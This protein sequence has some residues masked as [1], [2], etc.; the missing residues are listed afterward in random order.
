M[1]SFSGTSLPLVVVTALV[2]TITLAAAGCGQVSQLKGRKSYKD[3]NTA[4]QAQDYKKAADL[5]QATID[6]D[7][8]AKETLPA[9][10]FLAN[11]LDNLYKPSKKGDPAN[12][13]LM[14]KAVQYYQMAAE[15]LNAS[16]SPEYKKLGKLS[17]QYLV[18][19]YGADKLNDPGKAEPVL[20][21]M[22]RSDPSDIANYFMLARLYEDAGVYD[23][24][25]RMFLAAKDA[26]PNDASV[27]TSLASFYNRQN[28][29]D[30]TID[31]LEQ[32]AQKES[33]NPEAWQT[34]AVYYQDEAR[35]DSRLKENEKRD[36]IGKGLAAA[37]KA[38]A[39]K[40]DYSDAMTYKGLLL[41]LQAN[42]EKDPAKQQDLLKKAKEL[43][44][45][46][47]ATRKKK[48]SGA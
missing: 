44:D 4:Y 19:A 20:Q 2:T 36:Y 14:E 7:P 6:A 46:S 5:Y 27:Y 21:T 32:R 38:L 33:N 29:F 26:K 23:E 40:P 13:A 1:R 45:Q 37:D 39:I 42:L 12:D 48:A 10:F 28:K 24:A 18:A 47:E 3:A 35:K 25:E 31:A 15:K 11:C 16:D 8:N 17:L 43:Q 22:I 41:R 9:Y 30:K 34:I